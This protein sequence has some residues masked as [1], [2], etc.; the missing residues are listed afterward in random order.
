VSRNQSVERLQTRLAQG[1]NA[2]QRRYHM[3][4]MAQLSAVEIDNIWRWKRRKIILRT[5]SAMFAI[6][7]VSLIPPACAMSGCIM[8]IHPSSKYGRTSCRVKRRSPSYRN[9]IFDQY[10]SRSWSDPKG[11]QR[12]ECWSCHIG[13][14][15]LAAGLVKVAPR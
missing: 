7:F 6:F 13:S 11:I 4:Y 5:Y 3:F 1:G 2:G 9:R 10:Q 15:T 14:L 12:W 8:S